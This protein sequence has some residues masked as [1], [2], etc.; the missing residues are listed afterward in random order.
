MDPKEIQKLKESRMRLVNEARGIVEGVKDGKMGAEDKAKYDKIMADVREMGE[1]ATRMDE[2]LR[3]ETEMRSSAGTPAAHSI[4]GAE[5]AGKDDK[6]LEQYRSY[7]K[8]GRVGEELRSLSSDTPE[9][10]GY[11]LAPQQVVSGIRKKLD[12]LLFFRQFADVIPVSNADS[13]GI[14]TLET[15]PSDADWTSEVATVSEDTDMK[16]GL[17]ELKPNL[18]SKLVKIPMALLRKSA[19]PLEQLV[20]DRL[21]YKFAVTGE[22]AF[23]TGSGANQPLGV[24]TVSA[25]GINTDRNLATG[26]T[27][28]AIS[29]ANLIRNKN[30]LKAQYLPNARWIAHREF[31]QEVELLLDGVGNYIWRPG[32]VA[33]QPDTLLGLPVHRSEYAPHAFTSGQR[34]AVLG[35]FKFYQIAE[36]LQFG[37]QR[38]DQLYAANNKIGYIGRMEADG[39][40]IFSEAFTVVTMNA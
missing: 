2:Q 12:D 34:V 9:D 14:P 7:L 25:A 24:F 33:G 17:R 36:S 20:N 13:L 4:P 22:K 21:G 15:D 23:M 5:T 31:F 28:T 1:Q 26:N 30:N 39:M 8:N 19:I 16:F 27:A 38:L 10:G 18:V 6:R 40:P 3:L 35:D 32:L 37:I 29:A 11:I